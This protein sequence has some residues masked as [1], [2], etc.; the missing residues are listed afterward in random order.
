MPAVMYWVSQCPLGELCGKNYTR[1]G[2]HATIEEA[3]AKVVHHLLF[4]TKHDAIPK[5]EA[6]ALADAHDYLSEEWEEEEAK[7]RGKDESKG[8]GKSRKPTEKPDWQQSSWN[9]PGWRSNQWDSQSRGQSSQQLATIQQPQLAARN[10]QSSQPLS[11]EFF[12]CLQSLTRSEA[13]ARAAARVARA[14]AIAF[15][16]EAAVMAASLKKLRKSDESPV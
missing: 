15:E 13:S 16:D 1:L 5:E 7:G 10:I 14:A 9:S 4:S 6:E 2:K 3:R 8:Q 11:E 12:E